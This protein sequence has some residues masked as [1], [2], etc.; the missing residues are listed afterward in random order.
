MRIAIAA[1]LFST[2]TS[3]APA[4][5]RV[6]RWTTAEASKRIYKGRCPVR[7]I[8]TGTMTSARAGEFT[9][10]WRR[11]DGAIGPIRTVQASRPGEIW[12]VRQVWDVSGDVRGWAQL[13][14][15]SEQ[16]GSRAARF[17]VK[18]K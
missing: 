1:L 6:V 17:R 7:L 8:F 4:N 3:A 12:R 9:Y 5:G 18:C 15:P 10:A 14:I 13:W 16:H 11:S 2:S